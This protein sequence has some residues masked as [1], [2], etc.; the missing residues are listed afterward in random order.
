MQDICYIPVLDSAWINS[1]IGYTI[2]RRMVI[3]IVPCQ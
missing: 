2:K 3:S 1:L